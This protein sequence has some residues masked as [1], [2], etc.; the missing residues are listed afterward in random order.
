MDALFVTNTTSDVRNDIGGQDGHVPVGMKSIAAQRLFRKSCK[1][2]SAVQTMYAKVHHV[3][4]QT[5][6]HFFLPIVQKI[7]HMLEDQNKMHAS[8]DD[9]QTSCL[10][11]IRGPSL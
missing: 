1:A 11:V 6:D 4:R 3:G 9:F 2:V 5:T 8:V 10:G 7:S